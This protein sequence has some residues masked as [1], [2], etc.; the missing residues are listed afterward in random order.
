MKPLNLIMR[1][2]GPYAEEQL[3][4][5]GAVCQRDLF[6]IHG[7]TGGGKTTILDAIC[8]ALYGSTTGDRTGEQM[9]C[10]LAPADMP[11][12][13]ELVFAIGEKKY[14]VARSP[15][16]SKPRRG[17]GTTDAATTAELYELTESGET[18]LATKAVS[19]TAAVTTLLGFDDEQF[20]QVIMLPQGKFRELLL[21][22]SEQREE[23]LKALFGTHF[24]ERLQVALADAAKEV[25]G[26]LEAKEDQ[27]NLLLQEAGAENAEALQGAIAGK[28]GEL[29]AHKNAVE[30]AAL[31]ALAA[32]KNLLEAK[33][34][35]EKL[36]ECENA[37]KQVHELT[38]G[39][40]EI[41][42]RETLISAAGRAQK[43][44]ACAENNR[45]RQADASNRQLA[46]QTLHGA[47]EAANK[48]A[49]QA[50][51]RLAA[52]AGKIQEA[53][54]H[55]Q[56]LGKLHA[57]QPLI[58][59]LSDAERQVGVTQSALEA[60]EQTLKL[61]R[62]E[63]QK[64]A[65]SKQQL[66]GELIKLIE[67]SA[68]SAGLAQL[69][70]EAQ[71]K[72]EARVALD[73]LLPRINAAQEGITSAENQH[74]DAAQ[75]VLRAKAASRDLLLA[76]KNSS[77]A[78]LAGELKSGE[79]CP[80]CG[81]LEHPLPAT[82]TGDMPSEAEL[83][84]A[85][86]AVNRAEKAQ[87]TIADGLTQQ[88]KSLAKLS[89]ERDVHKAALRQCDASAKEL[90]EELSEAQKAASA[91]AQAQAQLPRSE[92]QAKTLA[93]QL[94]EIEKQVA[95]LVEAVQKLTSELAALRS[96][97]D[98]C[99][100]DLPE[101]LRT[102]QALDTELARLEG[103]VAGAE[104]EQSAADA[105]SSL[106]GGALARSDEA[107]KQAQTEADEAR[108]L[109]AQAKLAFDEGLLEQGFKSEHEYAAATLSDV[110]V[111]GHRQ[112]IEQTRK[113]IDAAEGR[114][115]RAREIAGALAQPDMPALE[116]ANKAAELASRAAVKA[117]S[118]MESS[119]ENLRALEKRLQQVALEF[120]E[121]EQ[122]YATIGAIAGCATGKNPLH[123]EF[124]R[125]VLSSL[126]DDVL[127]A[128]SQR[129]QV[130]SRGRYQLQRVKKDRDGRISGG[131]ELEVF[132]A[133]TGQQRSVA[134]LS[135]GESFQASLSLSLGLADVVQSRA[136]GARMDTM[137]IDEGFGSLDSEALDEAM[138]AIRDLQ[139]SG[140]VVG[141]I[142]HVPEL[143]Q[144]VRARIE[145]TKTG[146]G[147]R[148]TV[149]YS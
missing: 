20:R 109:E 126:L 15:K 97:R 63:Q 141:I 92:A 90:Q 64:K 140:R 129:L 95:G 118:D 123:L 133:D 87:Q 121:L 52:A 38:R 43:L 66:A 7:P 89:A 72:R 39:R 147:S 135:G 11:T 70:T 115:G 46:A 120:A 110:Q 102:Q 142:S 33:G 125:Y 101:M 132:D 41:E 45:Q 114:L 8:F 85:E 134:T 119:L 71:R 113:S 107:A 16:Q 60:K 68:Q 122:Q 93:A 79:A 98:E 23:I 3:I 37:Q 57:M 1:A 143:K 145:I 139:K 42:R 28:Q 83:K 12:E 55:Q 104:Q 5:L 44:H 103:L 24:Y 78:R 26:K 65:Q 91:A 51:E 14:R 17:G 75:A 148:A 30:K 136:G 35:V 27:K 10:Q 117:S 130:M 100:A 61:G 6:L 111:Q 128:A 13:V 105:A 74:G 137:F 54:V 56:Q 124:H 106:A 80:V 112:W 4:D 29:E 127:Y 59:R 76:W 31:T 25:S 22:K 82:A 49:K 146:L 88:N 73:L 34:I 149:Y 99:R 116:L 21:A 84:R 62:D 69:A 94:D 131:L 19:V 48:A 86:D 138:N 77:A 108:R 58:Q 81:S 96:T 47:R 40:P 36:V 32:Q 67:L 144:L 2:F 9:R 53:K 18:P 50:L